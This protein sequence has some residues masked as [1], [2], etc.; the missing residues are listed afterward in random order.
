MGWIYLFIASLFE[1]AWTFSLKFMDFK[2]IR[3]ISWTHFFADNTG[4]LS[5][6]PLLGYIV[7]GLGNVYF[8]STAMKQIP[9]S[10]AMAVWLGV[11][12]VGVKI[13]DITVYKQPIQYAQLFYFLLILIGVIG[14]RKTS[15]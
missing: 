1:I 9:T 11:A 6:A 15:A 14:L 13:L 2:K 10:T 7:F 5:L 8:Y 4:I 3:A 12:L